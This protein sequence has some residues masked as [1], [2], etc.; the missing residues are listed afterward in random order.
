MT[1]KREDSNGQKTAR[2]D[3]FQIS[4]VLLN[5]IKI[6]QEIM[7]DYNKSLKDSEEIFSKQIHIQENYFIV[8]DGSANRL[9]YIQNINLQTSIIKCFYSA[10]SYVDSIRTYNN[11]SES[12]VQKHIELIS[13]KETHV[14]DYILQSQIERKKELISYTALLKES[15]FELEDAISNATWMYKDEFK[16]ELSELINTNSII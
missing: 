2:L 15:L 7:V 4:T 16:K 8:F 10:K 12:F 1:F 11:L 9:G 5:E 14:Q 13:A 3:E 6:L